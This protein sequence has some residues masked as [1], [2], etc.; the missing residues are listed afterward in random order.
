VRIWTGPIREIPPSKGKRNYIS[1]YFAN[2]VTVL[3]V[4]Y[5]DRSTDTS[6]GNDIETK[7]NDISIIGVFSVSKRNKPAY[8]RTLKD[9]SKANIFM[10]ILCRIEVNTNWVGP[11]LSRIEQIRA[12]LVQNCPGSNK[13]KLG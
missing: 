11:K 5:G 12:G 1:F 6:N 10:S 3:H 8:S 13:N 7:R 9:R 4:H 2:I